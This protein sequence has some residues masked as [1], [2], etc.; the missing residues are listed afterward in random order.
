MEISVGQ[1]VITVT[2]TGKG[3][4]AQSH[5][6]PPSPNQLSGRGLYLIQEMADVSKI[7]SELGRGTKV[8][9]VINLPDPKMQ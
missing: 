4:Q 8:I 6:E 3:F 7:D 5:H 2:D 9:A 1:L